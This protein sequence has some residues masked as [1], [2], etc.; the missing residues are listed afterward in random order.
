LRKF[1]ERGLKLCGAR[2]PEPRLQL[3]L[4]GATIAVNAAR[5]SRRDM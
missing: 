1:A 5:A 3:Q 2:R 4:P